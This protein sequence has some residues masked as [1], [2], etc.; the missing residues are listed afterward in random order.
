M[1]ESIKKLTDSRRQTTDDARQVMAKART[2]WA[3]MM[4]SMDCTK[5]PGVNLGT[6]EG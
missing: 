4:S 2:M 1:H 6:R 5:I 3:K